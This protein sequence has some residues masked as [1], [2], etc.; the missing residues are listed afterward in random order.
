[1]EKAD[2]WGVSECTLAGRISVGCSHFL[3]LPI[4]KLLFSSK[5]LFTAELQTVSTYGCEELTVVGGSV[6]SVRAMSL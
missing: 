2:G 3:V 1:M 5:V 4:E 6:I